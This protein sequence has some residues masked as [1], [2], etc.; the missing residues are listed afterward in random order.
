MIN[1]LPMLLSSAAIRVRLGRGGGEV[2][3]VLGGI[4]VAIIVVAV[5]VGPK[6]Q[7]EVNPATGL[8][9]QTLPVEENPAKKYIAYALTALFLLGGLYSFVTGYFNTGEYGRAEQFGV[10]SGLAF[11]GAV[12]AGYA[13]GFRFPSVIAGLVIGL[14][15]VLKPALFGV[16]YMA[17]WRTPPQ[18]VA[19]SYTAE[20]H[21]MWVVPGAALM[22]LSAL[23]F[24]RL[25][26][27]GGDGVKLSN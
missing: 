25:K 9:R 21:L 11:G 4:V 12:I 1:T 23:L 22:F 10:M 16:S 18:M 3:A 19:L 8:A 24:L 26:R 7:N 15:L 2:M 6:K 13:S 20:R 27:S 5:I 17:T 14:L